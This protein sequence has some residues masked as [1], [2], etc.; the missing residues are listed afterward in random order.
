MWRRWAVTHALDLMVMAIAYIAAYVLRFNFNVPALYV[1]EGA[2]AFATVVLLQVAA[3]WSCGCYRLLWQFI[4]VCDVARFL[5]AIGSSTLVLVLL[6]FLVP[7]WRGLRPPLSIALLNGVLVLGGLLILRLVWRSFRE[8]GSRSERGEASTS[9]RT[10]LIGAGTAGNTVARELRQRGTAALEVVGF[11]DDDSAKQ[12]TF[13][14][15]VPVCGTLADFSR[16]VHTLRVQEVIVSMV[17]APRHVVRQVV[18]ACEAHGVPVRIAPGYSEILDGSVSVNQLREVDIADLLGREEVDLG[19]VAALARFVGGQRVLI[20][21]AGG[22]IGSELARQVAHLGPETLVLVERSEHALYEIDRAVRRLTPQV[23][24]VVA[25][26]GDGVRMRGVLKAHRPQIVLHAAAHKHVPLLES[27]VTEAVRNNVLATRTL[28]ELAVE[29]GVR[30]LVLLSTDKAVHP[31]SVMGA[32]KR[33]AELALQDLNAAGRTKFAAVRFGNVLGASGSVVP[34]FREQIRKGGPLTVTHPDMRRYFMT[35][36]EAV[37]LVLH[38]AS[39]AAGGEI[40]ILDMGEPVRIVELAE[41]MIRLSGFQPYEEMGITYIGMRPG[42]KLFEELSTDAEHA[43]KTRHARIFIG[44]I[45]VL[46]RAVVMARLSSLRAGC[47]QN[48]TDE[49]MRAEL[50]RDGVAT[51]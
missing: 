20:T 30:V 25:D 35:V 12:G 24:P 22:T 21:G 46:P 18:H 36:P 39:L 37:R 19:D 41:E 40:F 11:L 33:L 8:N 15:G 4:S 31:S 44:K 6:R 47:A 14:Q 23:V 16:V 13:L 28:G 50:M 7:E 49:E 27:N 42:E 34:L 26:I 51:P 9:R 17:Q 3:L 38:A 10:L 2:S 48:V 32:T 43:E 29:A 1:R 45:P 5:R